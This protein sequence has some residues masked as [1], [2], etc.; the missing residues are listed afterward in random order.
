MINYFSHVSQFHF[1]KV[2][3]GQKGK[4][5]IPLQSYLHRESSISYFYLSAFLLSHAKGFSIV[6]SLIL[7][8]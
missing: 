2:T 1:N 8:T 3:K 4:S 5:I 7:P 6:L